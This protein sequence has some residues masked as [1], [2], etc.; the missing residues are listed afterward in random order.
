MR[1]IILI[2]PVNGI[3]SI[4]SKGNMIPEWAT[5]IHNYRITYILILAI[6]ILILT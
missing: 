6:Y 5:I 3:Y 1:I 2:S 4:P